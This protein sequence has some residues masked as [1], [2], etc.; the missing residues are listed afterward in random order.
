MR[1]P[2]EVDR[3]PLVQKAAGVVNLTKTRVRNNRQFISYMEIP[4]RGAL[5]PRLLEWPRDYWHWQPYR[6]DY[7]DRIEIHIVISIPNCP[8]F[9]PGV[10]EGL[11]KS[12][13]LPEAPST[14]P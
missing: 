6:D 11:R 7:I 3:F 13:K 9:D 10:P 5:D 14:S 2:S 8:V 1:R 4:H 12:C